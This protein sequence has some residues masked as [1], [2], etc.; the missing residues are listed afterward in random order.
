MAGDDLLSALGDDLLRRILH[1]VPFKEAAAT[2]VLSRRWGSLWRSSG[3]ANLAARILNDDSVKYPSNAFFSRRDAFARAAKAAL[4]AA[5]API[6][7]LTL[8]V[9]E[10]PPHQQ[11]YRFLH[12][13]IDPDVDHDV[14]RA[15][16]T[17]RTVAP[18]VEELRVVVVA[19]A[20]EDL[21]PASRQQEP[22]HRSFDHETYRLSLVTLA[23][24]RVLDLTRCT[25]LNKPPS[26]HDHAVFPRV[27]TLRLRLC[28]LS[29]SDVQALM[30]AAPRLASRHPT[31]RIDAPRLRYF[32]Y[33]GYERYL[34]L[35]SLAP[36][37]VVVDLHLLQDL[38]PC[39][40]LNPREKRAVFWEFIRSFPN[41][42]VLKLKASNL[43]DIAVGKARRGELL[44]TFRNAVRLELEGVHHA[45]TS[46]AAAVAIANLLRCCPA[47]VDLRLR[48]S[49]VPSNSFKDH[50]YRKAFLERE[51]RMDYDKSVSRFMDRHRLKPAVISSLDDND[52]LDEVVT[53]HI[54]GLSGHSLTCLQTSLRKVGLQFRMDNSRCFGIKLVKFF[55]EIM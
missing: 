38:Y 36:D 21:S 30:D 54:P 42:R 19:G 51:K 45:T 50:E 24:L 16:L 52:K 18:S 6:T 35:T 22:D 14:I 40:G 9:D 41:A 11:A 23:H 46:K 37:M 3:A 26:M 29:T 7:R 27:E 53:G 8:R 15:L 25:G 28:S 48:L 49:T 5:D 1:F 44:C 47:L 2:S 34:S 43:K 20:V 10:E 55:T 12:G 13:T 33:K 17:H 39:H 4:D 32:W 31:P